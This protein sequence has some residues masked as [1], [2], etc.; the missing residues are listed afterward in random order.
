MVKMG[1]LYR[2]LP[3]VLLFSLS[4]TVHGEGAPFCFDGLRHKNEI[5]AAAITVMAVGRE[6]PASLWLGTDGGWLRHFDGKRMEV[7]GPSAGVT[8]ARSQAVIPTDQGVVVFGDDGA[9]QIFDAAQRRFRSLVEPG[10]RGYGVLDDVAWHQ[11]RL[12]LSFSKSKSLFSSKLS[13]GSKVMEH[14]T[15]SAPCAPPWR[16]LST[17][18]GLYAWNSA[19]VLHLQGA[20]WARVSLESS[21]TI[22]DAASMPTAL[23][24]LHRD[25]SI[26][27][28]GSE[29]SVECSEPF[30]GPLPGNIAISKRGIWLYAGA[31][32]FYRS[33]TAKLFQAIE[34][35]DTLA[36][37]RAIEAIVELGE[38]DWLVARDGSM[39]S[40]LGGGADWR[41]ISHEWT[42]AHGTRVRVGP[43][44]G[45]IFLLA[46]GQSL[47]E[48]G[49]RV[50]YPRRL[51]SLPG[52]AGPFQQVVALTNTQVAAA[53]GSA[54]VLRSRLG[55][56][57][58]MWRFEKVAWLGR[59]EAGSLLVVHDDLLTRCALGR[60]KPIA[61]RQLG[62]GSLVAVCPEAWLLFTCNSKSV[63]RIDNDEGAGVKQLWHV[64]PPLRLARGRWRV[65]R[66]TSLAVDGLGII[67]GTSRGQVERVFLF[68]RGSR[69]FGREVRFGTLGDFPSPRRSVTAMAIQGHRLFAALG[70]P[71]PVLYSCSLLSGSDGRWEVVARGRDWQGSA[72][73][74]LECFGE[75]LAA[76]VPEG[77]FFIDPLTLE[78]RL[79]TSHDGTT[80]RRAR[81]IAVFG[82]TLWCAGHGFT[83]FDLPVPASSFQ[84]TR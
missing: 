11:G 56:W 18:L 1:A 40:R 59:G 7:F 33:K 37:L 70:E 63:F 44:R 15:D 23:A 83:R 38:R 21:E 5:T 41:Y 50:P 80:C 24:L 12:W 65:S 47:F 67:V 62:M 51:L 52:P 19:A 2:I 64:P 46:C 10:D 74:R 4:A 66:L 49:S 25:G 60:S 72:I 9:V 79:F 6:T 68:G 30:E 45:G 76:L 31:R 36:P 71:E 84:D 43:S 61:H 69:P 55:N 27:I 39:W 54:V 8:S 26:S 22:I 20:R 57:N 77:V 13:L 32:V 48:I 29:G 42:K 75:G 53:N 34:L 17:D 14:S 82:R 16:F 78:H 58:T 28:L 73:R 3:F 35:P 81:D